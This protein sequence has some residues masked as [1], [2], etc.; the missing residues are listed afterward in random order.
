M[1]L[2][3]LLMFSSPVMAEEPG[4]F[5]ILGQGEPAPF[6]GVLFDI[7]ATATVLTLPN[8]LENK[9]VLECDYKIGQLNA[10]HELQLSQLNIRMD[11]L[12]Q[13]YNTAITQKDLEI[14]RLQETLASTSSKNP[15][16]WGII[17][18]VVGAGLTVGIVN[19]VD[20]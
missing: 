20:R 14:V 3:L 18:A 6:E 19:A 4:N 1:F 8:F 13:E 16:V 5:T 12:T 7:D 2:S 11:S 9:F 17:G 10:E 15:W